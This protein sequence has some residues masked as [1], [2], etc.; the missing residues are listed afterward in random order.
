MISP[1]IA[2]FLGT[3]VL[4]SAIAFIGNP[5]LIVGAFAVAVYF[6]GPIS[7]AHFN[8]AVT[9]WALLSGKLGQT[10]ALSYIGAQ[11]L[12]A[13]AVFAAKKLV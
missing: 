1:V 3:T 8:P 2:E 5:M 7:G 13:V 6:A 9:V 11:L 12:A 4:I 10:K